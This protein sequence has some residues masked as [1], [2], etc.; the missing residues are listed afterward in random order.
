MKMWTVF[1]GQMG[2]VEVQVRGGLE[3][4]RLTATAEIPRATPAQ[5]GTVIPD[6]PI[7]EAVSATVEIDGDIPT[8]AIHGDVTFE[9]A[10]GPRGKA[11]IEGGSPSRGRCGSRPTSRRA[12]S[13]RRSSRPSRPRRST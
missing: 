5:L 1:S 6:L 3:G 11:E 2:A 8:L 10:S 4:D 9:G 7:H 13:S 12:R